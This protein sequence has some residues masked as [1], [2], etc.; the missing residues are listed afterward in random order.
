MKKKLEAK[1]GNAVIQPEESS[2]DGA[3]F[4]NSFTA[5]A[6]NFETLIPFSSAAAFRFLSSTD[7]TR[8]QTERLG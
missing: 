2:E 7:P 8:T 5:S 6:T 4:R 1:R 3:F